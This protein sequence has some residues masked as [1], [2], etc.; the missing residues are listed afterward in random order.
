MTSVPFFG[1]RF[2]ISLTLGIAVAAIACASST[3]TSPTV[4]VPYTQTDL[5][6]GTG[7]EAVSGKRL[8]VD[9]TGWL[10]DSTRPDQKGQVFDTSAG[11]GPYPFVLGAGQVIRGWDQGFA[12]M[13][14]GGVRRLVIPPALGYGAAGNPPIPGNATLIF[15]VELVD[16]Q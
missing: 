3:P 2:Q 15:D 14:V 10:Y 5:R 13:R 12:G 9:Y 6:V 16:V 8:S 11:R 1:R 4:D 7:A